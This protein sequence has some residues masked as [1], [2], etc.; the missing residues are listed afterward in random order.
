MMTLDTILNKLPRSRSAIV[1]RLN[2]NVTGEDNEVF[3]RLRKEMKEDKDG[4]FA[5][6]QKELRQTTNVIEGEFTVK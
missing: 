2:E 4:T 5:R 1:S 3:A 6:L